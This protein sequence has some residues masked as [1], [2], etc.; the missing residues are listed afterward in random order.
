MRKKNSIGLIALFLGIIS[1]GT[2]LFQIVYGP[3]EKK[4]TINEIISNKTT[5]LKDIIN[6]KLKKEKPTK[7]ENPE[8]EKHNK[9]QLL[10]YLVIITS[11]LSVIFSIFAFIRREDSRTYVSAVA[12]SSAGMFF[13]Y[14]FISIGILILF[15]YLKLIAND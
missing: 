12:L 13:H 10:N 11:F 5:E 1:I 7:T 14:I 3:L 8:I 6:S 4:P 9:D 15:I 2:A